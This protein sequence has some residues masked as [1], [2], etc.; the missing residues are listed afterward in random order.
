[1]G[2]SDHG[3]NPRIEPGP[4]V[5]HETNGTIP[6]HVPYVD[7]DECVGCN[8]CGLICPVSGCITMEEIPHSKGKESWNER[9]VK[10]MG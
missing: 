4:A 3:V 10:G 5:T 7:K 8:L 9:V 2:E 1:M 6:E